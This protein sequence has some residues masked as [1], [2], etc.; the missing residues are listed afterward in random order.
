[1]WPYVLFVGKLY[2][3]NTKVEIIVIFTAEKERIA[4]EKGHQ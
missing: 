3:C 2:I 1:M 4:D